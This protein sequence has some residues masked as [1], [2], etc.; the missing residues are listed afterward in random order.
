MDRGLSEIPQSFFTNGLVGLAIGSHTSGSVYATGLDW[1]LIGLPV[2]GSD[3]SLC[4]L[5]CG[6]WT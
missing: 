5:R 3:L 4:Q 6:S 1:P 2:L